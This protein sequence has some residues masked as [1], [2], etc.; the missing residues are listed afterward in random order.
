MQLFKTFLLYL[1][2]FWHK[3]FFIE[4]LGSTNP[5][6]PFFLLRVYKQFESIQCI[7]T[8]SKDFQS[9]FSQGNDMLSLKPLQTDSDLQCKFNPCAGLF[10]PLGSKLVT[11]ASSSLT[12]RSVTAEQ[13]CL[14]K[15]SQTQLSTRRCK[16]RFC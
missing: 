14:V 13:S 9:E 16:A 2:T 12:D 4:P 8:L 1:E 15:G 3:A 6:K 5:I 7:S 11:E 10:V